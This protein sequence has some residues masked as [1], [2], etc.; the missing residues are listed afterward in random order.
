MFFLKQAGLVKLISLWLIDLN[1]LN[2]TDRDINYMVCVLFITRTSVSSKSG[3]QALVSMVVGYWPRVNMSWG[4]TLA[5]LSQPPPPSA[6]LSA[7]RSDCHLVPPSATMCFLSRRHPYVTNY[8]FNSFANDSSS[9]PHRGHC[10][11]SGGW[12]DFWEVALFGEVI[13]MT[14]KIVQEFKKYLP[15]NVP[16]GQDLINLNWLFPQSSWLLRPD[17]S[18][19]WSS[20]DNSWLINTG[21][22]FPPPYNHF[23][24]LCIF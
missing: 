17:V 23:L 13:H 1:L 5:F 18:G 3:W 22:S 24:K 7:E 12:Q 2:Y 6:V 21:M 20:G 19:L 15:N 16:N 8:N 14:N 9:H 10:Q 11:V 4:S